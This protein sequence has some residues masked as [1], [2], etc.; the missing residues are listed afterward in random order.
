MLDLLHHER[1]GDEY[2][3]EVESLH[4]AETRRS[5]MR[6]SIA[7]VV[8]SVLLL[9]FNSQS[10]VTWVNGFE[11]G[12]VQDAVV[13]LAARWNGEMEE[14]GLDA[15]AKTVRGEVNEARNMDWS[16]VQR[17]LENEQARSREGAR[18]L[19]GMLSEERG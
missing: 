1:E 2:G 7:L 6:M 13:S 3:E 12:P 9:A 18:L 16:E 17:W 10:L 11:V 4:E 19:R 8:A 15:P 14:Q 5:V